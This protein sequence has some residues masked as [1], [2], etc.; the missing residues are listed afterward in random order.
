V[1]FFIEE[2][3]AVGAVRQ[4]A[5][6]DTGGAGRELNIMWSL[7]SAIDQYCSIDGFIRM[8]ATIAWMASIKP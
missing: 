8:A 6:S 2:I 4:D 5:I 7:M 3:D 1:L